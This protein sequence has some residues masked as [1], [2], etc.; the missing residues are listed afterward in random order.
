MTVE[1]YAY[2][3]ADRV[4]VSDLTEEQRRQLAQTLLL[5]YLNTLYQGQAEFRFA[6]RP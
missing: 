2:V 3:G 5:R 1:S 4:R 6:Q